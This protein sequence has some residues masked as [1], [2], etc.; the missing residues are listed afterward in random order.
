MREKKRKEGRRRKMEGR[1]DQF[2]RREGE[3]TIHSSMNRTP[4]WT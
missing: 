3:N 2:R 1:K 4:E